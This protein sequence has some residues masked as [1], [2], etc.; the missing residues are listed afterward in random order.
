MSSKKLTSPKFEELR[1][2][3]LEARKRAYCHYSG[4]QVGAA[5]LLSDGSIHIGCNVE[6]S[7]YGATLCAE[8]V[9]IHS[10]IA[11]KGPKIRV[12]EIVVATDASPPW[13][14][15]GM[16]RQVVS[17]FQENAIIHAVNP[18]GDVQSWT[19]SELLP[20]AFTP[21]FLVVEKKKS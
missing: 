9:A 20:H 6:N 21:E 13:P 11:Q 2:L 18:Q 4:H 12:R 19:F 10:A 8:R 15:C 17:E 14:P 5:I 7:S 3:A 16:C 1:N